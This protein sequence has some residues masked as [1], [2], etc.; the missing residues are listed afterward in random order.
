MNFD[1]KALRALTDKAISDANHLR[2]EKEEL[3]RISLERKVES[4]RSRASDIVGTVPLLAHAAALE[5]NDFINVYR[6]TDE[7]SDNKYAQD[8]NLHP[9]SVAHFIMSMLRVAG[10]KPTLAFGH[11]GVGVNSWSDIRIS[12]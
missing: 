3:R 2:K 11:D 5:G 12:W 8:P 1:P 4:N 9:S 7:D 10:F 6:I